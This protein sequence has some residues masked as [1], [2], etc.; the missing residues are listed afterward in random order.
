MFAKTLLAGDAVWSWM[1]R[2]RESTT[3]LNASAYSMVQGMTLPFFSLLLVALSAP[4]ESRLWRDPQTVDGLLVEDRDVSDSP[5]QELRVSAVSQQV[6][7]S[8]C[9][10]ILA[11]GREKIDGRFKRREILRETATDRWIYEQVS[12]PVLR[13]RDYVV[14]LWLDHPPSWSHCE[15]SF[16]TED[17][18]LRPPVPGIVR[19]PYSRGHWSLVQVGAEVNLSYQVLSDPGEHLAPFLVRGGQREAAVEAVKAVLARAGENAKPK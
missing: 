17:D 15:L 14:H 18:P 3:R 4:S 11:E 8:L 2:L 10:A 9:D 5:Y 12:V 13:D 19:I 6:L 7:T 1:R 16:Q